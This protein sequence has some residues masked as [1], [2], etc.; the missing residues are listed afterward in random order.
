[1]H[2]QFDV[3][4]GRASLQLNNFRGSQV[5]GALVKLRCIGTIQLVGQYIIFNAKR[6]VIGDISRINRWTYTLQTNNIISYTICSHDI[7]ILY[8]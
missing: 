6:V 5:V 1:M 8:L 7:L 3:S 2:N 4:L